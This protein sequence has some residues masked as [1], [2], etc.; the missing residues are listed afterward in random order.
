MRFDRTQVGNTFDAHRLL[1]LAADRGCQAVVKAALMQAYFAD[2]VAIGVA[3][4]IAAV[5]VAA[6]L[7]PGEVAEVLDGDRYADAVRADEERAQQLGVNG[8]PFFLIDGRFAI[9]GAQNVERFLLGLRRAWE[10]SAA[11]TTAP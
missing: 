11:S 2:G 3:D 6:G 1:H 5:A 10:K 9:P 7:D 4:E 8:V